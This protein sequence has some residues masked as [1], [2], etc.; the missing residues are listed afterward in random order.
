V[1]QHGFIDQV[2]RGEKRVRCKICLQERDASDAR[3]RGWDLVGP[4]PDG[5]ANYRFYKHTCGHHQRI[6]RGNIKT[7]RVDCGACGISWAAAPNNLYVMRFRLPSNER[8][9]KLGHSGDPKSRMTFQLRRDPTV[10]G[11]L[12]RVVP[13]TSGREALCLEKKMHKQLR[14]LF[15]EKVLPREAFADALRVG[16]EVYAP[17]VEPALLAL[18]DALPPD[19]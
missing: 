8:V 11:E 2:A 19:T 10:E 14:C 6:A 9:I 4:D 5:K 12:L 1:R 7:G 3:Q 16:S 13:M 17:S 18:L 15:P